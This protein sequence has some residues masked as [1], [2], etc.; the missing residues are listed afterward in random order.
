MFQSNE[1]VVSDEFHNWNDN[2]S[3]PVALYF[4]LYS[5]LISKD[6]NGILILGAGLNIQNGT[7]SL[8]NT[9]LVIIT[10]NLTVV[11]RNDIR[12]TSVPSDSHP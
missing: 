7:L 2:C 5:L 6:R 11:G 9:L 3:A 10:Q 12:V 8:I 4:L 1:S